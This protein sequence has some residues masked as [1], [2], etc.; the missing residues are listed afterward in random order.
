MDFNWWFQKPIRC[1][2]SHQAGSIHHTE[3]YTCNEVTHDPNQLHN[4]HRKPSVSTDMRCSSSCFPGFLYTPL[5]YKWNWLVNLTFSFL[6][7]LQ[8]L[9][10]LYKNLSHLFCT[11]IVLTD[12]WEKKGHRNRI[13]QSEKNVCPEAWV[14]ISS[15]E[16][17]TAGNRKIFSEASLQRDSFFIVFMEME[18]IHTKKKQVSTK[19]EKRKLLQWRHQQHFTYC[20]KSWNGRQ[21]YAIFLCFQR[22]RIGR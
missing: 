17:V 13:P 21:E 1:Q 11:S 14:Q 15:N 12:L 16:T 2:A 5:I 10:Y 22:I 6:L 8:F 7:A 3:S 4:T 18:R 20:T 9:N 19:K